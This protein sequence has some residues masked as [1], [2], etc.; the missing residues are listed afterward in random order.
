MLVLITRALDEAMRTAGKLAAIGHHAILSPVLEMAPTGAEWPDGV[1]DAVLATSTQAFEL[2]S[3]T[4]ERP[5]PETRRLL[6][7]YVV[8]ER[9]L[10]AARERGFEGRGGVAPDAKDLAKTL[11]AALSGGDPARLVYLAGRDRKPDLEGELGA[12]GHHVETIEVYAAQPVDALDEEAAA[13]IHAGDIGA[14]MHYSRR[15]TE[16]FLNLA[17]EAGLDPSNLVHVAISKDAA[18]PLNLAGVASVL[19]AEEPKEQAMLA[20][21][22]AIAAQ[23]RVDRGATA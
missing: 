5:S 2:F 18:Q 9:T 7:V 11:V 8:G 14:V 4:Q 21:L 10:A 20:A 15:S 17:N 19:I 16:I 1:V 12:A 13:L 3:D 22:E 6:P 23:E